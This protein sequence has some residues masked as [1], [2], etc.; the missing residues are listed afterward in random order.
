MP[1]IIK[2]SL[3]LGNSSFREEMGSLDSFEARVLP[4]R[5]RCPGAESSREPGDRAAVSPQLTVPPAGVLTE[6]PMLRM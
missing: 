1:V 5:G 2:P 3:G 6:Q 4:A